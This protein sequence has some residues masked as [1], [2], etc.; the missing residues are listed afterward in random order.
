MKFA[1]IFLSLFC[2]YS[3]TLAQE[4]SILNNILLECQNT[5]KQD[6]FIQHRLALCIYDRC[7][8]SQYQKYKDC[9]D[10]VNKVDTTVPKENLQQFREFLK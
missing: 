9:K 2:Y 7:K 3:P 10:V 1:T 5:V 6:E 4:P 8:S